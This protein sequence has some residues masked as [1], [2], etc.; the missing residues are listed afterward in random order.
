MD[1]LYGMINKHHEAFVQLR[2]NMEETEGLKDLL[3]FASKSQ[4]SQPIASD[5]ETE[6][7]IQHKGQKPSVGARGTYVSHYLRIWNV[8]ISI[9]V[10]HAR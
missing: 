5:K 3:D 7:R 6:I 1:V 10:F 8:N 2:C 9:F 4:K